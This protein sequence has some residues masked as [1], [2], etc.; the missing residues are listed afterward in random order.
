MNDL[1]K[2]ISNLYIYKNANSKKINSLINLLNINGNPIP[3]K[4]INYNINSANM[5]RIKE[6]KIYKNIKTKSTDNI[7]KKYDNNFMIKPGVN[8]IERN[9]K[10]V[11]LQEQQ[12]KQKKMQEIEALNLLLHKQKQRK[13]NYINSRIFDYENKHQEELEKYLKYFNIYDNMR[14]NPKIMNEENNEKIRVQS[15]IKP[16]SKILI[17]NSNCKYK[18]YKELAKNIR[19][20]E[21]PK[22]KNTYEFNDF[23]YGNKENKNYNLRYNEE[24][25]YQEEKQFNDFRKN[26]PKGKRILN[27]NERISNLN[28]LENYKTELIKEINLLPIARLSRK[29]IQRKEEIEKSLDDIDEK[30]NKLNGYKEIFVEI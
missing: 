11:H 17:D 29:Q 26:S 12:F 4:K 30:I 19:S 27:E 28:Y 23:N 1:N 22:V 9:K 10:L 15:S 7:S 8:F 5:P 18:Y 14:I 13:Y 24:D 3:S 6:C 20:V 16:R 2:M 25:E 21:L